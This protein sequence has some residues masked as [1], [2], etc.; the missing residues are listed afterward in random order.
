MPDLQFSISAVSQSKTKAAVTA[1]TFTM[2]IDEPP[3][4]GGEDAGPNPVEYV[5]AALAGCLNVVGNLVAGE[6]NITLRGLTI[7]ISGPLDP[8][9]FSGQPGAGRAGFK[10]IKVTMSPD[11]DADPASLQRWLHTVESRC[12]VSDNLSAATPIHITLG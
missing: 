11:T 10:E 6:M 2:I 5:L 1:R 7:D 12:P 4:L 3:S 8:A 9:K